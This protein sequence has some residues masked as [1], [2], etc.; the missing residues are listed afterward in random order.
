MVI[1]YKL[2]KQLS[3]LPCRFILG[4]IGPS[5][6]LSPEVKSELIVAIEN[7]KMLGTIEDILPAKEFPNPPESYFTEMGRQPMATAM[8][9]L[10]QRGAY[11]DLHHLKKGTVRVEK[12]FINHANGRTFNINPGAVGTYGLVLSSHKPT[13]GRHDISTYAYGLHPHLFFGHESYYERI[14]K[15]RDDKLVVLAEE[16]RFPEYREPSRV[17]KFEELVR[18][19][20]MSEVSV[21]LITSKP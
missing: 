11:T 17:A 16:N 5:A 6:E 10:K 13:G 3:Y 4:C 12:Q 2:R 8:V 20:P 7:E 14:M 18:T 19:L 15:W 9:I 21:E 1:E